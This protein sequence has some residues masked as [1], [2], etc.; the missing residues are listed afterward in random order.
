M[1]IYISKDKP[2]S[3]LMLFVDDGLVCCASQAKLD[4]LIMHMEQH[5]AITR[6]SAD[7]YVG[8]HIH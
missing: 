8:L 2:L 7:L 1:R 6:S 4:A 5:F 3:I